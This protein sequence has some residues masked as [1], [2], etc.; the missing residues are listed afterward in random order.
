MPLDPLR[1]TRRS[2]L[3]ASAGA[4]LTAPRFTTSAQNSTAASATGTTT[5][6]LLIILA[7]DL[8]YRDLSSY[9]AQDLRTP[10]IDALMAAGVRFDNFYANSPVCSPTRAALLSGRYPDCT[11]VPGVIRADPANNSGYLSPSAVLVPERLRQAGYHTAIVGKW[12]LGLESPNTPRQR[13]VHFFHGFLEDMMDGY[14]EH[15]RYGRNYMRTGR[16]LAIACHARPGTKHATARL[17]LGPPRG[18]HALPGTRLL[19]LPAAQLEV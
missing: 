12:H 3:R 15:R 16:N 6:N 18:P 19:R 9:G 13:G 17:G 7:D 11:G 4:V 10:N 8:G 2:L 5:P 1:I 14:Y